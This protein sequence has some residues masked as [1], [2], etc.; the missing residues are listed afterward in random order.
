MP[1]AIGEQVQ[2]S[3][4]GL[5]YICESLETEVMPDLIGTVHRYFNDDPT[6]NYYVRFS[7]LDLDYVDP[8]Y[9]DSFDVDGFIQF[10]MTEE[11]LSPLHTTPKEKT[12]GFKEFQ[13][14]LS[15]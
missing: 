11:E 7:R 1:F 8:D 15:G 4:T 5:E 3:Y 14:K 13:H 2:L 6:Q 10:C 12:S 9:L